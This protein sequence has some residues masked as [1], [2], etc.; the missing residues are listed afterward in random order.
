MVDNMRLSGTLS[1]N[2]G[3]ITATVSSRLGTNGVLTNRQGIGN[4]GLSATT[5]VSNSNLN[6]PNGVNSTISEQHAVAA[7]FSP[8]LGTQGAL[9]ANQGIQTREIRLSNSVDY[10]SLRNKP[11]I[12]STTLIGDKTS[13]DLGL[14]DKL[15]AGNGI[16]ITDNTI[17]VKYVIFDCGTS[18]LNTEV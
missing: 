14:Q 2:S 4:N 18:T 7:S 1:Q 16:D 13:S 3:V 10:E 6:Q 8:K 12:N 5:P 11:K 17:S 15:T 9:A